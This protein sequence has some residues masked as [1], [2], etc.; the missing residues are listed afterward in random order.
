M[1]VANMQQNAWDS[2]IQGPNMDATNSFFPM[3]LGGMS[4]QTDGLPS[5]VSTGGQPSA[6][7]FA[8]NGGPF[9]GVSVPTFGVDALAYNVQAP[10]DPKTSSGDGYVMGFALPKAS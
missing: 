7:M 9:M 6:N 1:D 8:A 2:Y 4:M 3:D 5:T 10:Q